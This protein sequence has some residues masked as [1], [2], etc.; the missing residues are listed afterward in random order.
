MTLMEIGVLLFYRTGA[1]GPC[2]HVPRPRRHIFANQFAR[3]D[4]L[5]TRHRRLSPQSW[6]Q[7][8]VPYRLANPHYIIG[9]T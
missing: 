9:Y 2:G 3:V 1:Q 4:S 6:D 7:N 5:A 8:P